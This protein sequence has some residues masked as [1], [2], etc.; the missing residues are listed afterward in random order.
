VTFTDNVGNGHMIEY[1]RTGLPGAIQDAPAQCVGL[2]YDSALGNFYGFSRAPQPT[3]FGP[4]EVNGF[5]WS[6]YDFQSTGTRFCGDLSV[7]NGLAGPPGGRAA[8]LEV[9]RRLSA[10]PVPR[11]SLSLACV[12]EAPNA[13]T[14]PPGRQ[15]LYELSGPFGFGYSVLG[16]CGMRNGPPFVGSPNFEVTLKGVPHSLFAMLFIGFSNTASAI[17]PLPIPLTPLLGWPESIL[18]ISP[19]I[20]SPLL[21]PSAPGEFSLPIPIPPNPS[22]AYAP[23][24]FQWLAIDTSITGGLALSQAGKTVLYR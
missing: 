2:G 3:P 17:G 21:L 10:V 6:G 16:R 15:W 18:S 19:D 8:G 1:S 20:S 12:V 22:L 13:T 7:Q 11:S 14:T 4:I 9:Y 24:F 23:L 5:E